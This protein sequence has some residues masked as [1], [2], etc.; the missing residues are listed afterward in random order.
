MRTEQQ[1]I[2]V[3]HIRYDTHC[4]HKTES[5]KGEQETVDL[6]ILQHGP[7]GKE[8]A[9][10]SDTAPTYLVE[11]VLLAQVIRYK[12]DADHGLHD[13]GRERFAAVVM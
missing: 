7:H 12:V 13:A 10:L 11:V 5:G 6:Q 4:R 1:S 9:C 2:L 3:C 8:S